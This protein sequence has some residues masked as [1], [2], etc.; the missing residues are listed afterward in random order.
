MIPSHTVLE[1]VICC[2]GIL[3]VLISPFLAAQKPPPPF[4][5]VP[6]PVGA[7]PH[8]P[9]LPL[10]PPQPAV[11]G[12]GCGYPGSLTSSKVFLKAPPTVPANGAIHFPI[13]VGTTAVYSCEPPYITLGETRRT[14]RPDATWSGTVPFCGLNVA[15]HKP[16]VFPNL[17]NIW[18]T[19]DGI[20]ST[21]ARDCFSHDL[22]RG[23]KLSWKMDLTEKFDVHSIRILA[24]ADSPWSANVTLFSDPLTN[25]TCGRIDYSGLD[26]TAAVSIPCA[27]IVSGVRYV[28]IDFSLLDAGR[29]R[30]CEVNVLA[31]DALTSDFCPHEASAKAVNQGACLSF[32]SHGRATWGGALQTCRRLGGTLIQDIDE[33]AQKF[34]QAKLQYLHRFQATDAFYWLGLFRSVNMSTMEDTWQWIDGSTPKSYFWAPNQPDHVS[35][36]QYCGGMSGRTSWL[37]NDLNCESGQGF[38]ICRTNFT[39]CPIPEQPSNGIITLLDRRLGGFV[40]YKCEEGFE[41]LGMGTR[42]C[43]SSGAWSG[44]LPHCTTATQPAVESRTTAATR[45]TPPTVILPSETPPPTTTSSSETSTTTTPLRSE[46]PPTTTS[47]HTPVTQFLSTF[48]ENAG[49]TT[50]TATTTESPYTVEISTELDYFMSD[51]SNSDHDMYNTTVAVPARTEYSFDTLSN[52]T[53][54]ETDSAE[55]VPLAVEVMEPLATTNAPISTT[56]VLVHH[57]LIPTES[58]STSPKSLPLLDTLAMF[59]CRNIPIVFNAQSTTEVMGLTVVARYTCNQ[60]YNLVGLP[61]LMCSDG[62]WRG[63]MPLCVPGYANEADKTTATTTASTSTLSTV[64]ATIPLPTEAVQTTTR[65]IQTSTP[66][67]I[68]STE[69]TIASTAAMKVLAST[70]PST[71]S[72]S[73][74]KEAASTTVQSASSTESTRSS[75]N[76]TRTTKKAPWSVFGTTSSVKSSCGALPTVANAESLL[77]RN[78]GIYRCL[79][80]YTMVGENVTHCMENGEW[81][82]PPECIAVDCGLPEKLKNGVAILLNGTSRLGSVAAYSCSDASPSQAPY[83]RVCGEEGQWEGDVPQCAADGPVVLPAESR[84]LVQQ[85]MSNWMIV[86]IGVVGTVGGVLVVLGAV[87]TC[88]W[89]TRKRE[90]VPVAISPTLYSLHSGN[91]P[92]NLM[93]ERSSARLFDRAQYMPSSGSLHSVYESNHSIS[94][95]S[96]QTG[97]RLNNTT[98][99]NSNSM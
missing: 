31:V 10:R 93:T 89:L 34:L 29:L 9:P 61:F 2:C 39:S 91:S 97:R 94:D 71:I 76:T 37:W 64:P 15:M 96:T 95:A 16:L 59:R 11:L 4:P 3:I 88:R 18:L 83:L 27:S 45:L 65:Q 99:N 35:K 6:P 52:V 66:E 23:E 79:P 12:T 63:V 67:V 43:L 42:S 85:G 57:I 58:P 1:Y 44:T 55:F 98:G 26:Q 49:T 73:V 30:V 81:E 41:M 32:H 24:L 80:G 72:T 14:C 51:L 25:V 22:Q 77:H 5:L 68:K 92:H 56:S 74:P 47:P 60:G 28:Q 62:S 82:A 40:H 87:F 20:I 7:G 53:F 46:S 90:S 86:V 33:D 13:P 75:A 21:R 48:A 69:R 19:N 70:M 36:R 50:Q 54:N 84:Q 17:R 38:W 78:A 8:G